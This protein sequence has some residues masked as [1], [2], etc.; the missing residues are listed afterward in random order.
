[1]AIESRRTNKSI[2]GNKVLIIGFVFFSA[3]ATWAYLLRRTHSKNYDDLA[4]CLTARQVKMYGLYWC[5]HCA[6]QKQMFG[7]SFKYVNYIECGVKGA[8]K[9]APECVKANVKNFPTWDFS[10]ERHEGVLQLKDIAER[11]GCRLP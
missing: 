9:E 11:S 8:Q 7:P 1:M 10:G 2:S 5:T 3:F 4:R 6:D